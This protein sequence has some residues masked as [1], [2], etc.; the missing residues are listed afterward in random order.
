M[1]LLGT[2]LAYAPAVNPNVRDRGAQ[3]EQ[4]DGLGRSRHGFLG[5]G[6]NLNELLFGNRTSDEPALKNAGRLFFEH[7]QIP[8]TA[9][10]ASR[11]F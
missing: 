8:H 3:S 11:D 7:I 1:N 2:G 6:V 10:R 5:V 4:A 9:A